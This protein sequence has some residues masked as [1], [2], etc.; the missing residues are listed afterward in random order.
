MT[1]QNLALILL[2]TATA[3]AAQMD[4]PASVEQGE[5]LERLRTTETRVLAQAGFMAQE[6]H[7]YQLF[8][9]ND[10]LLDVR[11][12]RRDL[13]ADLRRQEL[14]LNDAQRKR[15]GAEQILRS[16]EKVARP[17]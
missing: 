9:V 15:R 11:R 4:T 14:S 13:L 1:H 12:A 17:P 7:C 2:L 10:C 6:A 3:S 5:R 8:A 16:D